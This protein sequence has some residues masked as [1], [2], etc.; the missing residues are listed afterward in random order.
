MPSLYNQ[1]L[2]QAGGRQSGS[3]ISRP[4]AGGTAMQVSQPSYPAPP[5]PSAGVTGRPSS[6]PVVPSAPGGVQAFQPP[7][8]PVPPSPAGPT[9]PGAPSPTAQPQRRQMPQGPQGL[10]EAPAQTQPQPQSSPTPAAVTTPSGGVTLNL[11]RIPS[12]RDYVGLLPGTGISTP[13][14]HATLGSDGHPVIQFGSPE[15]EA[16]YRTDEANYGKQ[17][18]PTP[19]S[20]MP[21]APQPQVRLGRTAY[22]PFS[23]AFLTP[24][25]G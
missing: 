20:G 13:Y 18:G 12:R 5:S 17:Y 19:F 10:R 22:N 24:P 23:G 11:N 4:T 25:Q 8:A 7:A 6:R 2:T 1:L 21:G 15:Q 9:L 16:R 3:P 14:G